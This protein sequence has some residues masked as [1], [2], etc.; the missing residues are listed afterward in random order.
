MARRRFE[1]KEVE[2]ADRSIRAHSTLVGV[3]AMGMGHRRKRASAFLPQEIRLRNCSKRPHSPD[4]A[5]NRR[6]C[7]VPHSSIYGIS[8]AGSWNSGFAR[9]DEGASRAIAKRAWNYECEFRSRAKSA[10]RS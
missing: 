9:S 10:R 1:G 2:H 7:D 8:A 3:S 6:K 4:D 5:E